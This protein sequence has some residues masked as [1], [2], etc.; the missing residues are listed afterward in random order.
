[1]PSVSVGS[2]LVIVGDSRGYVS[3]GHDQG[4]R[5]KVLR[6]IEPFYDAG[7]EIRSSDKIIKVEGHGVIGW[8][9]P[10][11]LDKVILKEE[12]EKEMK[13]LFERSSE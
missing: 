3:S 5:V 9:K 4:S 11:E 10:S 7:N 12:T 13:K 6:I 2:E 1:M 8:I